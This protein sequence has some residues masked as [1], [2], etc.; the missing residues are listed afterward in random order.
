[1]KQCEENLGS[2]LAVY[3]TTQLT[4][5]NFINEW[6]DTILYNTP[7]ASLPIFTIVPLSTESRTSSYWSF[8]T[9]YTKPPISNFLQIYTSASISASHHS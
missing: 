4:N 3:C 7:F 5:H 6:A 8:L 1:M 9:H 2:L